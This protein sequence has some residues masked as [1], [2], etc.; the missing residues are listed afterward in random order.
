MGYQ[1]QL[2]S[3]LLVSDNLKLLSLQ[4]IVFVLSTIGKSIDLLDAEAQDS[5]SN[6][7]T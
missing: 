6:S 2:A 3:W 5:G 7:N 4:K 1:A